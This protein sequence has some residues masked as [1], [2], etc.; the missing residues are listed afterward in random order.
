MNCGLFRSRR[1]CW[2]RRSEGQEGVNYGGQESSFYWLGIGGHGGILMRWEDDWGGSSGAHLARQRMHF[3]SW[4]W[5]L[6]TIQLSVE[7]AGLVLSAVREST[8]A[9][10]FGISLGEVL[11]ELNAVSSCTFPPPDINS[12]LFLLTVALPG[13]Y[14]DICSQVRKLVWRS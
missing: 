4:R 10:I 14:E 11:W 9:S 8:D 7:Q 6:H 12:H 3:C 13:C 5:A 1:S 2:E